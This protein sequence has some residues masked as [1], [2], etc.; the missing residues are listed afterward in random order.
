MKYFEL[1]GALFR[2]EQIPAEVFQGGKFVPYRGDKAR[3]YNFG[4]EIDEA[5][6]KAMMGG[7]P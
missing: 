3:V 2:G 1:D 4:N 7:R 6:A 5:A